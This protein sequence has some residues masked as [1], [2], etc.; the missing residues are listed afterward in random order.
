MR[1]I[2]LDF[3]FVYAPVSHLRESEW[4]RWTNILPAYLQAARKALA[5]MGQED[6]LIF[7][8]AT[9]LAL[10]A[11]T[12]CSS[13][14]KTAP[15]ISVLNF[16]YRRRSWPVGRLLD[17]FVERALD[18]MNFIGVPSHGAAEEYRQHFPKAASRIHVLPTWCGFPE[19]APVVTPS[20]VP[21]FSGG[22][23]MRDYETL[24]EALDILKVSA[25]IAASRTAVEALAIPPGVT[26]HFDVAEPIFANL[27]MQASVVVVPL[28]AAGFD[29]GQSVVLQAMC[30]GKPVVATNT[31]G[32]SEYIDHGKT[33]LLVP[34]SDPHALAHAIKTLLDDFKLASSLGSEA[35]KVYW[36]RYSRDAFVERL[37]A[38][39]GESSGNRS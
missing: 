24:I 26:L 38:T 37:A 9:G 10:T 15:K 30:Y 6:H 39:F 2:G 11:A 8:T 14:L 7:L 13:S 25:L 1:R 12:L 21:V 19:A 36:E 35:R 16:I 29:A 31:A 4:S 23:S 22:R 27:M 18:Q 32:L 20:S 33:G 3:N 17:V 5:G 28:Q 34:P